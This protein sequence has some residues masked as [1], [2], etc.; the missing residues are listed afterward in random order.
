LKWLKRAG[1][2]LFSVALGIGL[3]IGG[4]FLTGN[5]HEVIAGEFYRSGQLSPEKFEKIIKT[6]GIKT[7]INLRGAS[8]KSEW[9]RDEIA[10]ASRLGVT[11]IDYRMSARKALT[12]EQSLALIAMM[13][14]APKPILVHCLSG[15]DRTGLVSVMYLQQVAGVDEERAEMQL[16]LL[17]GHFSIPY[18]N[19]YYAMDESWE[20]LEKALGIDS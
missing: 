2:L 3:Y 4:L 18:I 13:R 17:F 7:V 12:I 5:F 19:K 9:Y 8:L 15:I 16:S 14:T 20:S 10:Q 6:Y 11:H 1:V